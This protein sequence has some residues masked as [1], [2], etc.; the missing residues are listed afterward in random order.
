M[1][2]YAWLEHDRGNWHF[3]TSPLADYSEST[4]QWP[5]VRQAILALLEEGWTIVGQ[6]P[7]VPIARTDGETVSGYGLT[8]TVH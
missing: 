7:G 2:R 6:Y 3:L 8:R 1:R 5:N 4:R